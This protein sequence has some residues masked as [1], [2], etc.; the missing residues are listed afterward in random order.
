MRE[1][2]IF[3]ALI[4]IMM[5]LDIIWYFQPYNSNAIYSE[6]MLESLKYGVTTLGYFKYGQYI[7]Y[8]LLILNL[9][10][11]IGLFF[12]VRAFRVVLILA[13]VFCYLDALLN[14]VLVITSID[15]IVINLISLCEGF[16]LYMVFYS[17]L[18]NNFRTSKK[19]I[20]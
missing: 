14:P 4:I 2:K 10:A 7:T 8:A 1:E 18:A 6:N 13:I 9:V 16:I 19:A 5:V 15:F 3:K 17:A 20:L 12:Y 11:A